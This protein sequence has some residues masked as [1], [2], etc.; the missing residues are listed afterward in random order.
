MS[1]SDKAIYKLFKAE[2][3]YSQTGEDKILSHLF[4]S[5]GKSRI[6]YLDIGTNHPVMNS[7]TYLFYKKGSRGVCVEPNPELCKIIAKAR[8]GD[9]CLNLGI[10]M[11]NKDQADFYLMSSHTLST[12]SK[13]DAQNL[14]K[15]GNYKIKKVLQIPLKSINSIV[16]ENFTS[17]IDLVSIDVEG[18]NE[19]IVE[20]FDFNANRPFCFCVETL[21][22]TEDNS[23][24]KLERI[25]DIFRRNDYRVYA[26]T[27]LNTIFLDNKSNIKAK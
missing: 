21:S 23:G 26:D 22:Y 11:T 8:P 6:S 17:P 25:F 9:K 5:L 10:G 1:F 14:D 27:N 24:I 18:W 13:E 20:S 2:L 19:D 15:G 16:K 3:T 4:N 7:N 12:F